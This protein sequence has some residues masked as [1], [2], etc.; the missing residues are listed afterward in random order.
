MRILQWLQTHTTDTFLFI[1]HKT[2]ILLFKFHCNV[3]IGVR[4]IKEMLGSVASGTPCIC[5]IWG[6]KKEAKCNTEYL[7]RKIYC[8]CWSIF[9]GLQFLWSLLPVVGCSSSRCNRHSTYKWSKHNNST[10]HSCLYSSNSTLRT[11]NICFEHKAGK[12]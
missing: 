11:S 2:N 7:M 3:F 9:L 8:Y 5:S 4:I 10:R 12:N 6:G 1:S